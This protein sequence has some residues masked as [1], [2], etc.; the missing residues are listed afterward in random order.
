MLRCL[1]FSLLAAYIAA[2]PLAT[3]VAPMSNV[4]G[5]DPVPRTWGPFESSKEPLKTM[6][7]LAPKLTPFVIV[8]VEP[9]LRPTAKRQLVRYGPFVMPASKA[10]QAS[11]I[12]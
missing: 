6:E 1:P 2:L 8:D 12:Y 4:F 9:Q 7:Q 11:A 5:S 3:T 10:S